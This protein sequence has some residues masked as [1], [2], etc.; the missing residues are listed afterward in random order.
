MQYQKDEIMLEIGTIYNKESEY[1][2]T[3]NKIDN[4]NM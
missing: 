4:L 2:K 3:K 1:T